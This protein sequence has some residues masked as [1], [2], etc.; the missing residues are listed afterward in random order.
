MNKNVT[1]CSYSGPSG[2]GVPEPRQLKST[3]ASPTSQLWLLKPSLKATDI[4]LPLNF[5]DAET[6]GQKGEGA[7]QSCT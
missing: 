5:R 3:P 2:D 1:T 7:E 4:V 6:E